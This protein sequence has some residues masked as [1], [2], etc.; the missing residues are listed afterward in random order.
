MVSKSTSALGVLLCMQ[1]CSAV[2]HAAVHS[3]PDR[4]NPAKSNKTQASHLQQLI[5]RVV[6]AS[7]ERLEAGRKLIAAEG[8]QRSA[9]GSG[10]ASQR[11]ILQVVPQ[12]SG[13]REHQ[14]QPLCSH[15]PVMSFPSLS[16]FCC[17]PAALTSGASLPGQATM[18]Q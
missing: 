17:W 6:V 13:G 14:G 15:A 9:H 8:W 11:S 12:R 18:R 16:F 2:V 1:S 5:S 10:Q 3:T 7:P 4:D